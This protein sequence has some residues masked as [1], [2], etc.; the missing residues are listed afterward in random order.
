MRKIFMHII[1]ITAS[2]T[3]NRDFGY[4]LRKSSINCSTQK[5]FI[6]FGIEQRLVFPIFVA[7]DFTCLKNL[8]YETTH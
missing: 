2:Q 3:E 1:D 6:D 7:P 5:L 4:H 8:A